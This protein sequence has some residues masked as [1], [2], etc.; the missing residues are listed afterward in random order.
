MKRCL[1]LL[2][3]MCTLLSGC[4]DRNNIED[5]SLVLLVGLDLDEDNRLMI[6]ASSPV[7]NKEAEIKEES[8]AVKSI[9]LR[10]SRDEFD[11]IFTALPAAGKTQFVLIGKRVL[12]H[13][14]W[15]P[16]LDVFFRDPRNTINSRVAMVDGSAFDIVRFEPKNKPRLP[17]FMSKLFETAYRGNLTVKTTLRELQRQMYE[18]GMTASISNIRKDDNLVIAGTALLDKK[19][20]YALSIGSEENKLLHILQGQTKGGFSFTLT[21]PGKPGNELFY[22]GSYSFSA[23]VIS[24]KTKAGYAGDKFKFDVGVKMHI[25]LTERHFNMDVRNEAHKLEQDIQGQLKARFDKLI[26]KA[27]AAKID[28]FGYGLYARAY[29]YKQWKEVQD[30]WGEAFSQAEVNVN[31]KVTI[32]SMGGIR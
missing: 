19:G 7:F 8:S 18:K 16:L 9:T 11:K 23:H 13:P 6:S 25:A 15:F 2:F 17:L 24:T 26:G 14:D 31:V 28:P 29:T 21:S 30:R 12:E 32:A 27:Q 20:R 1:L 22:P 4:F 5:V 3:A 10:Q